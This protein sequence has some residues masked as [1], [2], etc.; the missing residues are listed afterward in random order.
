MSTTAT[1]GNAAPGR[2]WEAGAW[3]NPVTGVLVLYIVGIVLYVIG[4]PWWSVALTGIIAGATLT[5]SVYKAGIRTLGVV[6]TAACS[7]VATAWA[8]YASTVLTFD[9][10]AL[11]H[12]G[13]HLLILAGA[14]LPLAIVWAVLLAGQGRAAQRAY[15][16]RQ[17]TAARRTGIEVALRSAG[18]RGW[19]VIGQDSDADRT[20][21][22]C[23][24]APGGTTF[25]QALGMIEP[26]EI[27]LKAPFAGA[28]RMEQP[29]G[30]NVSQVTVS[31]ARRSVLADV[32]TMPAPPAEP[33]SI[34]EP[35]VNG[36]FEDGAEA[37]EVYAYTSTDAIGQRDSGKTGLQNVMIDNFAS[38]EDCLIWVIDF[39]EGSVVRHWLK[40]YADGTAERPVIDWVGFTVADVHAMVAELD[41]IAAIRARLRTADKITPTPQLPAI[42]LKIDEIADLTAMANSDPARHHAVNLLIKVVRKHRSEG[43]DVDFYSQRGTMSMLG[44]NARDLLSQNTHHNLLR[45]DS[46]TE[47]YN[48]L[49]ISIDKLGGIDPSAFDQPGTV[50]TVRPGSRRA[51]RKI[52]YLPTSE[53]PARAAY[54]AA[55]RPAL[56]PAALEGASAAYRNRWTNPTITAFLDAIRTD[57]PVPEGMHALTETQATTTAPAPQAAASEGDAP[58]MKSTQAARVR[59]AL[60]DRFGTEEGERRYHLVRGKA[61]MRAASNHIRTTGLD[62]APTKELIAAITA[63][64]ED[65]FPVLTPKDLAALLAPYDVEPVQLGRAF[66]GNPRGYRLA[67][68]NAGLDREPAEAATEKSE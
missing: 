54:Y 17:H 37:A 28:V 6:Y 67:D 29:K 56:E 50:L 47:V 58:E 10:F 52:F 62:A 45:V 5:W 63:A 55:W 66:E 15:L 18:I 42:R 7:A 59:A 9:I 4:V 35:L 20:S 24:I 16:A 64:D 21:V 40:P 1:T 27:A 32:L 13:T 14:G 22:F 12:T 68:L 8:A 19:D 11:Q 36:R 38:C 44:P 60:H 53:I 25:R 41:R 57:S 61:A 51:V 33:R 34:L 65:M 43:L 31:V 30:G 49:S 48:T 39:K 3:S 2:E 23:E 26:L 46:P